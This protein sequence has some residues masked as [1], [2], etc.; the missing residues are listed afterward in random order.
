MPPLPVINGVF[1]VALNWT[2]AATGQSAENV[3]HISDI[4]G[5]SNAVAAELDSRAVADM[6]LSANSQASVKSLSITP[7]DGT[8]ATIDYLMTQDGRWAGDGTDGFLPAVATIVKFNSAMRG[9][10]NNGR[11]F[12]PFTDEGKVTDGSLNTGLAA[13]MTTAWQSWVANMVSDGFV[14]CVA[15]Y[16]VGSAHES[17]IVQVTVEEVLGTQRR[18]QGRLR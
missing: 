9:R 15:S 3:I 6:W 2:H 11:L 4:G 7:L 5:S 10:A 18:R 17:D 13:T 1:R 8:S 14:P 12:I 16:L